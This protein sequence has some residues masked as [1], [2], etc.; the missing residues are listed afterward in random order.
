MWATLALRDWPVRKVKRVCPVNLDLKDSKESEAI[1]ATTDPPE[2]PVNRESWGR[3]VYPVRGDSMES[4]EFPAC[5][6]F[7]EPPAAT[8]PTSTSSKWC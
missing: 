1:P 2:T 5:P 8:R 6:A 7:K 4:G 3:R